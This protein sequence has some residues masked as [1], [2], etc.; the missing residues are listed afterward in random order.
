MFCTGYGQL[1][2]V[3]YEESRPENSSLPAGRQGALTLLRKL[4][5]YNT[6]I[7]NG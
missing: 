4:M 5:G 3:E 1:C 2:D 7:K 6:Y